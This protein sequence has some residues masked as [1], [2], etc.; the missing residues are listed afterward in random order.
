MTL[1]SIAVAAV[2]SGVAL[3]AG[4]ASAGQTFVKAS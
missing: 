2:L 1:K 4:P 3:A